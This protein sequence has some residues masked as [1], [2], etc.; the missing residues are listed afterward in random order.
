MDT[1]HPAGATT[2]ETLLEATHIGAARA[3]ATRPP[4]PF[5]PTGDPTLPFFGP[6]D[7]AEEAAT[8]PAS[9]VVMRCADLLNEALEL[10]IRAEAEEVPPALLAKL[11][12][13]EKSTRALLASAVEDALSRGAR[14]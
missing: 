4:R 1:T 2:A 7:D 11:R 6:P 3:S 14:S 5:S 8:S 9:R 12:K 10:R 13:H